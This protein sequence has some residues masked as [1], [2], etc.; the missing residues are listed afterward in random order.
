MSLSGP[1]SKSVSSLKSLDGILQW[2]QGYVLPRICL[3]L[4]LFYVNYKILTVIQYLWNQFQ[5]I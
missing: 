5:K 1:P 2:T 3:E 4:L